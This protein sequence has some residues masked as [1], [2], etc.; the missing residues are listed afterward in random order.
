MI[1]VTYSLVIFILMV[2][3]YFL[4]VSVRCMSWFNEEKRFAVGYSDGQVWL[5]NK[6]NYSTSQDIKV[7]A[8]KV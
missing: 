7:S 8:H 3:P 6:D 2:I 4:T 1:S 5:V